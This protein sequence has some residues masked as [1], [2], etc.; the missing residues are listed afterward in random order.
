LAVR[1]SDKG[2]RRRSTAHPALADGPSLE[3]VLRQ[4]GEDIVN[5]PIPESLLQ[6]L[7]GK[8][9]EAVARPPLPFSGRL[10]TTSR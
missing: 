6:A 10:T 3:E 5:D 8:R 7:Q 2:E 1:A 9:G 4:V